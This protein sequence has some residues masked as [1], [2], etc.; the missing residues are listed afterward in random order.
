MKV[1]V[2][3]CVFILNIPRNHNEN[4]FNKFEIF[5]NLQLQNLT[6]NYSLPNGRIIIMQGQ[7]DRIA[8]GLHSKMDY[9][10]QHLVVWSNMIIVCFLNLQMTREHYGS[11]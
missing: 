3:K 7:Y 6:A 10:K 9:V 5:K 11:F 1:K 4:M 8:I 2:E